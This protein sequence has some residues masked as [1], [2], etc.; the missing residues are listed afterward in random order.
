MVPRQQPLPGLW[1]GWSQGS[2]LPSKLKRVSSGPDGRGSN[3]ANNTNTFTRCQPGKQVGNPLQLVLQVGCPKTISTS[4]PELIFSL[5]HLPLHLQTS[6]T[7]S[8]TI[9]LQLIS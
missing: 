5:P 8:S 9:R 2:K 7:I 1:K 4:L 3:R 6:S